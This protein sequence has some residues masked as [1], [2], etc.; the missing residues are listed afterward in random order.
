MGNASNPSNSIYTVPNLMTSLRLILAAVAAAMFF[1]GTFETIAVVLC[2]IGLLLDAADGWYARRFAQCSHLGRFM[3]P[4]ADKLLIGVIYAV[5]A[6]N[7]NSVVVWVLFGLVMGREIVVTA[8]RS[9]G[10]YRRGAPFPTDKL[11]KAKMIVQSLAGAVILTYAYV[12]GGGFSVLLYPVI[13]TLV[14]ITILS[15]ISAGRY[16]V[17][18]FLTVAGSRRAP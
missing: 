5:I 15:Y 13:A 4:L 8:S 9:W 12:L 16:L 17:P 1:G 18:G 10:F 2:V 14:V 3:D 6:I 7:L 11:G